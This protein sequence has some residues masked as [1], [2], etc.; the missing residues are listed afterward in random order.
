MRRGTANRV[1]DN[2]ELAIEGLADDGGADLLRDEATTFG[3]ICSRSRW[4]R[5]P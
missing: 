2:V 3:Q 1:K 4:P 5:P